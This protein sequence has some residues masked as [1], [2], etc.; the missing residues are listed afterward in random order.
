MGQD[1]EATNNAEGSTNS[2][3][4]YVSAEFEVFGQVQGKK[5]ICEKYKKNDRLFIK[6]TS[7]CL[8]VFSYNSY[9]TLKVVLLS[10][11]DATSPNF[12]KTLPTYSACQAG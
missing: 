3:T 6:K 10:L 12:V 7:I 1:G 8:M 11:Q 4:T 9:S 5:N 2:V